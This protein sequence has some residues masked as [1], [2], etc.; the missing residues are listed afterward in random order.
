MNAPGGDFSAAHLD[1][2]WQALVDGLLSGT[3]EA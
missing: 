2:E 3:E 1:E